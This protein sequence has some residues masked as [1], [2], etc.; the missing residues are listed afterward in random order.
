MANDCMNT[1]WVSGPSQQIQEFQDKL[2]NEDTPLDIAN[3]IPMPEELKDTQSPNRNV[4]QAQ[5]MMREYGHPDWYSWQRANWGTKI[6]A[7]NASLEQPDQE[8]LKYEYNT[9]SSPFSPRCMLRVAQMF[10]DLRFEVDYN[11][12]GM[13]FIGHIW[14]NQG[15]VIE[16]VHRDINRR[17]LRELG[18]DEDDE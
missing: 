17:D 5:Q 9:A 3:L 8:S 10:P 1:M 12:P 18:Y 11:E 15:K 13:G 6:G 16:A 14:L 4:E 2:Q 7:Y